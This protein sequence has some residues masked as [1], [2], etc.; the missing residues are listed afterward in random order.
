LCQFEI[1]LNAANEG[2]IMNQRTLANAAV[3]TSSPST[4]PDRVG[5]LLAATMYRA[6]PSDRVVTNV[7]V[8]TNA[9]AN[10]VSGVVIAI[11]SSSITV[12]RRG[13]TSTYAITPGTT[14]SEGPKAI[15]VA[16]LTFGEHVGIHLLPSRTPTVAKIN[17][18][19]AELTGKV[20]AVS[21][22]KITIDNQEGVGRTIVVN[23]LTTYARSDVTV[24]LS[25]LSIGSWIS[26]RG[27][28][29]ASLEYLDAESVMIDQPGIPNVGYG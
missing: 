20:T 4:A 28:F 24:S 22:H 1:A 26:A 8:T 13:A 17:I 6:W 18:Q 10:S 27:W 5:A 7:G 15:T 16:D 3:P 29:G 14:F 25:E 9:P 19:P 21:D 2:L 23:A 11:T 12:R